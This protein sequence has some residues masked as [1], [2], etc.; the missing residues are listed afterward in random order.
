MA[1]RQHLIELTKKEIV[2]FTAELESW[3]N[4]AKKGG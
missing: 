2:S 4:E 3:A 1:D